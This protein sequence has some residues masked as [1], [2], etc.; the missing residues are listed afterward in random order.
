MTKYRNSSKLLAILL[1]LAI[2]V[3]MTVGLGATASAAYTPTGTMTQ[4]A[5]TPASGVSGTVWSIS[6]DT[7]MGLFATYVNT[8]GDNTSG[9]TFYLTQSIQLPTPATGSSWT[10]IGPAEITS[11]ATTSSPLASG[12]GFAGTFDG[13][14]FTIFNL[15]VNLDESGL[16]LFKYVTRTGTVK[17]ITVLGTVTTAGRNDA[18]AGIVGY[19]EGVVCNATNYA[20]VTAESAYNV[21]GIVGFNNGQYDNTGG[22]TYSAPVGV[23]VNSVNHGFITGFNKTGGI[24][25]ENAGVISFCANYGNIAGLNASRSGI[26]G[27]AGRNGNNNVALE[28]GWITNCYNRGNIDVGDGS[29]GGGIVG[30]QNSISYT[31]NCYDT[32]KVGNGYQYYNT[33]IGSNENTSAVAPLR[34]NYAENPA[35]SSTL[36]S[37]LGVQPTYNDGTAMPMDS[38][39]FL[40]LLESRAIPDGYWAEGGCVNAGYPFHLRTAPV[41][42]ATGG[43]VQNRYPVIYISS[44]GNDAN[45]GD[46]VA[47]AVATLTRAVQQAGRSIVPAV[48]IAVLDT[49]TISDEEN[50]YGSQIPVRT[51]TSFTSTTMFIIAANGDLT[52]GGLAFIGNSSLTIAFDVQ[53]GGSLTVRNNTSIDN[54]SI[55]INVQ[56]NGSLTLN[57]STIGGTT[58]VVLADSTSLFYTFLSPTQTLTI[59]GTINLGG[60]AAGSNNG[61]IQARSTLTQVTGTLSITMA[62]PAVNKLVAQGAGDYTVTSGDAAMFQYVGSGTYYVELS[63][64][65]IILTD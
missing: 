65:R 12:D 25:G 6:S 43:N 51:D 53:S 27:I 23:I 63:G 11:D 45:E 4:L 16:G 42:A 36:P 28:I 19:N 54:A 13:Q 32:G 10:P 20:S 56:S 3:S 8:A 39:D 24:V 64:T 14:G 31:D 60:S 44:G 58:S 37:E 40:D 61:F 17:D 33:V 7:E 47:T 18:I 49:I 30:F 9:V 35:G 50:V 41:P 55:A 29:W 34:V 38:E 5:A 26:G 1:S 52:V 62:S 2:I 48:Y 21:G 59:S 22:E 57:Q 46:T 15:V